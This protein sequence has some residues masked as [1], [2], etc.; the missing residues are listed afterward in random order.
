MEEFLR[1]F[2]A[3]IR[4]FFREELHYRNEDLPYYITIVI[5]LIICVA[6]IN[7]FVDLTEELVENNLEVFDRDVT[8]EVVSWRS[9]RLTQFLTFITN[10]GDTV[11]Y[12][13]I[14]ALLVIFFLIRRY[15]WKYILQTVSVLLLATLSNMALK[16]FV[17]RSRPAAEHLV[18]VNTLSYPSGHAM[19]AMGFYGFLIFLI[20]RYKVNRLLKIP[21]ISLFSIL[22]F[23][24]GFSRIY[25]GVHFPSDVL[26]GYIGGLIWVTFCA[27]VFDVIDL[28]RK[29]K[30]R[31]IERSRDNGTDVRQQAG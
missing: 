30:L 21:L 12:I 16:E 18:S 2:I 28:M 3:F 10:V 9:D 27:I 20:A 22:I 6:A 4:R 17:N 19:S 1:R 11:G 29:R 13:V 5:A 14:I 25:L 24:I 23:L 31:K 26:A 15:N 7:G 8:A